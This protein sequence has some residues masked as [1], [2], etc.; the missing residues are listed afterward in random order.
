M[1]NIIMYKYIIV[2]WMCHSRS[3][4]WLLFK[5]QCSEPMR[6]CSALALISCNAAL[7]RRRESKGVGGEICMWRRNQA[8]YRE[9]SRRRERGEGAELK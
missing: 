2:T 8:Q 7:R 9:H 4:N 3:F 1:T 6:M 5:S